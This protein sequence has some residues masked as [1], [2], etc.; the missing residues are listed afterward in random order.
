MGKGALRRAKL[1][2]RPLI[3]VCAPEKL[4]DLVPPNY[5]ILHSRACSRCAIL[6][7]SFFKFP[8]LRAVREN[9]SICFYNYKDICGH[10]A[11]RERKQLTNDVII[12]AILKKRGI[13]HSRKWIRVRFI[14]LNLECKSRFR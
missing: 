7:S 11:Q 9:V 6:S 10:F 12:D 14:T 3:R 13:L 8:R 5:V 4:L 1:K 2:S